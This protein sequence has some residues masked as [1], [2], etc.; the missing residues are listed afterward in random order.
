MVLKAPRPLTESP[1]EAC[2]LPDVAPRP[3]EIAVGV[4]ACGVCRTDLQLCE[5]DLGGRVLPIVPGHQVVGRVIEAGANVRRWQR[6]DRVGVGW[7][8][9]ACGRCAACRRGNEN[10]CHAASFTGWD[11]AGGYA[12]RVL[13]QAD[14]A[15]PIPDAFDDEAAAPLL[16]GGVIGYRALKRSG[17]APGGRLGLYGFGASATLAIQV[18]RYWGCRV[19]VA[20]RGA[21]DQARARALGAEWSGSYEAMP[22]EPL[23]AA[24]TFAPS[25][26]VV[27][28]ALRA[29]D[30]GGMVAVNAIHVDRIPELAYDELWWER[31]LCSV[32]NYTRADAVEFLKLAADIPIRTTF[33]VHALEDANQ[34]LMR[35]KQGH[36]EGAC[37]LRIGST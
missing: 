37:V 21:A 9:G 2:E 5:G 16:C 29:L 10:L 17:I 7:L 36:V 34:A 1:L 4:T 26:D 28:A 13:V 18:A 12:S 11:R 19:F 20:T 35:C 6:G 30:R 31:G 14:F 23:D 8:G 27:R 24:V 3:D 25:G 32:A 15:L 22:P 33:E